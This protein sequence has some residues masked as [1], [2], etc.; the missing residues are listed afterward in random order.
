MSQQFYNTQKAAEV[1][2]VKPADVNHLREQ[3]KLHGYRDGADWKFKADDVQ[4]YLAE[5]IKSKHAPASGDEDEELV[6]G[7][8]QVPASGGSDLEL[9]DFALA[10]SDIN[11]G[12]ETTQPGS[13]SDLELDLTLDQDVTLEDSDIALA[14][15]E[16]AEGGSDLDVSDSVLDSEDLVL[17]GSGAGSGDDRRR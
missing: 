15:E 17:G 4:N 8:T 11:L 13:G 12:S 14:S 2:G 9:S 1:L 10:G 5:Q 6:L 3:N 16:K 7:G